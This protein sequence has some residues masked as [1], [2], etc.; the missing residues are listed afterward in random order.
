MDD[1]V[2]IR[3]AR[4]GD[5]DA[6]AACWIEFGRYYAELDPLRFRVPNADGLAEWFEDRIDQPHGLW[7]VGRSRGTRLR[8]RRGRGVA[9]SGPSRPAADEGAGGAGPEG[10]LAL[11][12]RVRARPG[13]GQVA[14]GGGGGL[15]QDEGATSAAVVAIADSPS[16]VPFYT[17]GLGYRP[18]TLGFWKE[19]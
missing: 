16:A 15:G 3:V 5:G 14:D 17:G 9:G 12:C 7:L 2:E 19:L 8:V 6:L 1:E 10:E 4:G 18:N 11:R 13:R